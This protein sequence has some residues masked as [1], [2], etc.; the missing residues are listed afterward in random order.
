MVYTYDYMKK[1]VLLLIVMLAASASVIFFLHEKTAK[2]ETVIAHMKFIASVHYVCDK[3]KTI[4]AAFYE[5][6]HVESPEGMPPVP[7]GSVE[8]AFDGAGST[9]LKQTISA[10]GGRYANQDESLIFWS[11][12]TSAIIMH[13]DKLDTEYTNC[14]SV[15]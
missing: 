3:S 5:G 6:A 13:G 8:V 9:T 4:Q 1:Y 10:D 12:G 11:K 14:K 7:T 15:E 2:E